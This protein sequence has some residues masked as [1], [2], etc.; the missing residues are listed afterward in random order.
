MEV[1]LLL[2]TGSPG[3]QMFSFRVSAAQFIERVDYF[4]VKILK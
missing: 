4:Q 3:G 1:R 2:R